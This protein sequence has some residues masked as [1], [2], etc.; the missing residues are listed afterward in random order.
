MSMPSNVPFTPTVN[1]VVYQRF[2]EACKVE[3]LSYSQGF[4]V[5]VE[6]FE[7]G[8]LLL[9]SPMTAGGA[10][11]VCFNVP[12]GVIAVVRHRAAAEQIAHGVCVTQLMV[13]ALRDG[14]GGEIKRAA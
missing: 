10:K 5:A 4:C 14:F 7:A 13:A 1:I 9:D 3:G 8:E 12:S 11:P 2:Q 6:C